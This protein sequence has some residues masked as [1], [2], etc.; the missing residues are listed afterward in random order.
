[1][2]RGESG[3]WSR[4]AAALL[5]L[6]ALG[7]GSLMLGGCARR[8]PPKPA[9]VYP[10]RI[11]AGKIFY[12]TNSGLSEQTFQG[13]AEGELPA[14]KAPHA[15]VL[16]SDGT[17]ILVAVNGW[18]VE[19]IETSPD[20]LAYRLVDRPSPSF[21]G[22]ATGGAWPLGGGYLVQLYRDP[23]VDAPDAA[24]PGTAAP[25]SHLAYFDA[26]GGAR[27]LSPFP[28]SL[29]P[30]FE[31]FALLPAE[32]RWYAELRKDGR[33]RVE[34]KFFALDDPLAQ[35]AA[36][37]EVRR[38]EFEEALHPLPLAALQGEA[39]AALRSALGALGKGPWLARLRS[40]SG[41]DR[42][43]LSSGL[44][45]EATNVLGWS[46]RGS[47]GEAR[48]LVLAGDGRL[49][50][51]RGGSASLL[52]IKAP[53]EGALFTA[54]AASDKIAAAAWEEGDFPSISAAGVVLMA[55]PQ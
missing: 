47:R 21:S 30:G 17:S 42:W 50:L 35:A 39:G 2:R 44:P 1:L 25:G 10:Y 31:A 11:E 4:G 46:Y 48:A 24:T 8:P 43:Y 55:I 13:E 23:F 40:G 15:S 16:S 54:L 22:L 19:S 32:G 3:F 5:A 49:A 38:A 34:L 51:G 18:G 45:E 9:I 37:R 41:L 36:P 14:S 28:A 29:D 52:S 20:G 53:V 7:P 6:A 27:S 33:E 26:E 12:A